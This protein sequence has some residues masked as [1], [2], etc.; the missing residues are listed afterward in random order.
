MKPSKRLVGYTVAIGAAGGA[1]YGAVLAARAG[2]RRYEFWTLA[3]QR[4]EFRLE[5]QKVPGW[6]LVFRAFNKDV[7]CLHPRSDWPWKVGRGEDRTLGA[8]LEWL[9]DARAEVGSGFSYTRLQIPLSR[10]QALAVEPQWTEEVEGIMAEE[11]E[12]DQAAPGT[13]PDTEAS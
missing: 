9:C 7:P 5:V 6:R 4:G 12:P 13:E 1:G 8:A 11:D 10:E 3:Y 2:R